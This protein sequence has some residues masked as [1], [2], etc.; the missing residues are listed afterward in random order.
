MKTLS[1]L[2][3]SSVVLFALGCDSNSGPAPKPPSTT[4]AAPSPVEST[5]NDQTPA[6]TW[7]VSTPTDDARTA[8]VGG[9]VFPKPPTWTWQPTSMRFRTLEYQVP[10]QGDGSGAAELVFSLF[11]GGD[12]GPTSMNIERWKG[13]FR[14]ADGEVAEAVE[15]SGEA[16][17]MKISMVSAAGHYK[18]MG[19]PAPRAGMGHASA[20]IEAPGRRIFVRLVGPEATV[21]AAEATFREMVSNASLAKK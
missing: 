9:V 15:E 10:G 14:T 8:T 19:A 17:G 18:S 21:N 7:R 4:A 1:L 13:Q 12:G 11:L 3:G 5:P 6:P 20:I 16:D 2:V